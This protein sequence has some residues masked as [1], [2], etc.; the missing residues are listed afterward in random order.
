M[1]IA[2]AEKGKA[3][4]E[5]CSLASHENMAAPAFLTEKSNLINGKQQNGSKSSSM[6]SIL[7][8]AKKKQIAY[9]AAKQVLVKSA[10]E[11]PRDNES[12]LLR[13][14]KSQIAY[15]AASRGKLQTDQLL[16]LNTTCT[17]T[18]ATKGP[19][20]A[21]MGMN[22]NARDRAVHESA[23][24]REAKGQVAYLSALRLGIH[25]E[26]PSGNGPPQ[27]NEIPFKKSWRGKEAKR[28]Y[29]P[30]SFSSETDAVGA[31]AVAP[32]VV[33]TKTSRL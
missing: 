17:P 23:F 24:L 9:L 5:P 3:D 4:N 16:N 2:Q 12:V 22:R 11:S 29:P 6:P 14:A 20:T 30:R 8:E 25:S 13:E 1:T 15:P 19:P 21:S 27:N 32:V 10:S 31:P 33:T 28:P 7:Q 26:S 18:D